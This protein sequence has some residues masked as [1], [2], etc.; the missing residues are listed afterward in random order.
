M[1]EI[2]FRTWDKVNKKIFQVE[3]IIFDVDNN[4]CIISV[5]LNDND[6]PTIMFDQEMR[7]TD[8]ILMQ[9]TGLKDKNGKEIYEGDIVINKNSESLAYENT[10]TVDWHNNI[11]GFT[12]IFEEIGE[13]KIL[14]LYEHLE[15]IGNI[16]ENPE[17]L[18]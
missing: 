12:V 14:G 2:K 9:Y 5:F 1:R 8:F 15:I 4:I 16:Y 17:L 7:V 6:S 18:K 10:S 13:D 11:S 3:R